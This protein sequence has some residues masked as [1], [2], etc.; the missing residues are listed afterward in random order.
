MRWFSQ[1]ERNLLVVDRWSQKYNEELLTPSCVPPSVRPL[2]SPSVPHCLAIISSQLC[3]PGLSILRF[4]VR[5]CLLWLLTSSPTRD[6]PARVGGSASSQA[7]RL[8]VAA[9]MLTPRRKAYLI[10]PASRVIKETAKDQRTCLSYLLPRP[11]GYHLPGDIVAKSIFQREL[12]MFFISD[13]HLLFHSNR[14]AT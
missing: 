5:S 1:V 2:A 12:E 11:M 10:Q 3:D 4:E 13:S 7:Q 9:F 14:C 6:C 8:Q